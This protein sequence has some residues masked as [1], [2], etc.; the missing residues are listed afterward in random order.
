MLVRQIFLN[1]INTLLALTTLLWMSC[2][3]P[4]SKFVNVLYP[5]PFTF[6]A[7]FIRAACISPHWL[8]FKPFLLRGSAYQSLSSLRSKRFREAKSEERGFRRF[9]REKIGTRAKNRKEGVGEESEGNTCG[10]TP[11]FWKPPFASERNSWLAGLVKHYWHVS[12]KGLKVPSAGKNVRR[13][14]LTFLTERVF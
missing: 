3:P 2:V 5:Y 9:A 7:S 4:P 12:I 11:W 8:S 14:A 1:L 13:R 10:Q 6:T